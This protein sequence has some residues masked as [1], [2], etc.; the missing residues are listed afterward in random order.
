MNDRYLFKGFAPNENGKQII[1]LDGKDI[2][3]EWVFGGLLHNVDCIKIREFETDINRIAKSF[4][5]IPETICQCTGSEDKNG[6]PIFEND[7]VLTDGDGWR[8]KVVFE[9][10]AMF[11]CVDYSVFGYSVCCNWNKF[12]V[13]GDNFNTRSVEE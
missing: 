7:I 11:M 12:E 1:T 6:K 10:N 13:I 4:V 9:E 3:G 8:A 5:I 2:R